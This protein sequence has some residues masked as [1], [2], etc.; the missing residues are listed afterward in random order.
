MKLLC[1]LTGRRTCS[2]HGSQ[3]IRACAPLLSTARPRAPSLRQRRLFDAANT[4]RAG[5]GRGNSAP[6]K[7]GEGQGLGSRSRT[8]H[9][10]PRS[11]RGLWCDRMQGVPAE[12]NS[13]SLP[14]PPWQQSVNGG[15]LV[16]CH[17]AVTAATNSNL[18][19][20]TAHNTGRNTGHGSRSTGHNTARPLEDLLWG[21]GDARLCA[22]RSAERR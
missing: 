20:L 7:S 9:G 1:L 11:S 5:E 18:V 22:D 16:R 10:T 2:G 21:T 14:R 17:R 3:A 4:C 12:V 13:R 8:V 6:L 15:P 19:V